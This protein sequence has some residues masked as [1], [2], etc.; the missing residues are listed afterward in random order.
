LLCR[1]CGQP[2]SGEVAA[3]AV[4]QFARATG[5]SLVRENDGV[6]NSPDKV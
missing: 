5:A 4:T 6:R 1:R 2:A 3:L